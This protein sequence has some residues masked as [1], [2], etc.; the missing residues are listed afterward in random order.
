LSCTGC[1]KHNKRVLII[2]Y[3]EYGGFIVVDMWQACRV[4]L[5][6]ELAFLYSLSDMLVISHEALDSERAYLCC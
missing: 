5:G 4:D 1:G 2:D 3:F 6:N